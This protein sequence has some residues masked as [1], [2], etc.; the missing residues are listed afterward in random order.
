MWSVTYYANSGAYEKQT[1]PTEKKA[2]G[3]GEHYKAPPL[4]E[5]ANLHVPTAFAEHWSFG[6]AFDAT[7]VMTV[8]V[9]PALTRL[10]IVW[11]HLVFHPRA[12]VTR[13]D[14]WV[15]WFAK[16]SVPNSGTTRPSRSQTKH[17]L[18]RLKRTYSMHVL[19]LSLHT[20]ACVCEPFPNSRI[21]LNGY[22]SSG[23]CNTHRVNRK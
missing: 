20:L 17:Q 11:H 14:P 13:L 21:A 16:R 23:M 19:C 1:I 18:W 5:I 4:W 3:A 10:E 6:P 8:Y 9:Q 7:A 2:C 22:I 12:E 15:T